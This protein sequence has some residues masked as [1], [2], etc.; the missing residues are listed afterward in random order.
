MEAV[1]RD[2]YKLPE[3]GVE[4]FTHHASSTDQDEGVSELEDEHALA[5][6]N[7]LVRYCD[8]PEKREAAVKYLTKGIELRHRHFDAIYENFYDSGEPIFRYA[9]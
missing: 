6:K 4:F 7:L 3:S 1:I 5:C 8:T 9:N 2:T